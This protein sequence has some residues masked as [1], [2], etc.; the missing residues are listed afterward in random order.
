[1]AT[2]VKASSELNLSKVKLETQVWRYSSRGF[3]YS[4]HMQGLA[5]TTH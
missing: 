3:D 4:S 5:C 1:M 2:K